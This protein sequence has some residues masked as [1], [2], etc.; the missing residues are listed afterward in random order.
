[1]TRRVVGVDLALTA[2]ANVAFKLL[3]FVVLTQLARGLG[4]A[5]FGFVMFALATCELA[6][7]A[8]EFG[9]SAHLTREV[10]VAPPAVRRLLGEVL[11]VRLVLCVAYLALMAL[12]AMTLPP[13]QGAAFLAIAVYAGLKDLSRAHSAAFYGTRRVVRGVAAFAVH[14]IVLAAG[15]WLAIAFGSG[16]GA[17]AIAYLLSGI[18]LMA[19]SWSLGR[20]FGAVRPSLAAWRPVVQASLPLFGLGL[21]TM[22]QLR[23]DSSLLG[24]LR[25]YADVATYEA[26]ARLF[27]ASQSIVRPLALVFLPIAAGLAARHAYAEVR[28]SLIQLGAL[29]LAAGAATAAAAAAFADPVILLVYG[30]AYAPAAEVMRIHFAATPFVFVGAVA[31]FHLT[32]L[33][34][35]RAALLCAA[36][37]IAVNVALDLLLIPLMGPAG[38]AI[39]TL[40]AETI[41]ASSMLALAFHTLARLPAGPPTS[42]PLPA[43]LAHGEA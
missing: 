10:A 33:R 42:G 12:F 8:T 29:A 20:E 26:S 21:L 9:S 18:A 7:L 25:P 15:I 39:A 34:R 37:S 38:A 23:I 28:R 40:A 19:I 36:A 32:A 16:A 35:E 13:G 27:E 43:G 3:G 17:V 24:L 6:A 30:A 22:I 31:L 1:M 11:G 2:S 41:A 5:E 14:L 4:P